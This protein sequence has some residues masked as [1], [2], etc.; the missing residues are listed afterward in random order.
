MGAV[1]HAHPLPRSAPEAQGIASSAIQRFI[2]AAER[3][4]QHLHSIMIMRHG[5]VVAEGWWAPY[6]P[7]RPHMLFSLSKSFTATGIGL[8]VAEGR[9][10]LNDAVAS[11][12]PDDA[13]AAPSAHLAA[14]RVRDLLSMATGHTVDPSSLRRGDAGDN[15]VRGFFAVPVEHAPGTHFLYNSGASYMLSAIVQR[16][17][18]QTLLDYLTP[19][20]F[21]PLGIHGATWETDPRGISVG[22]WGLAVTTEE[23]AKFGQLYLQ[24]GLWAG[25]RLLSEAWI[26]EAT[27]KQISNADAADPHAPADWQQGY[28][29][30][31]WRCQH[32]AYRGDGAFGQFCV[33]MPD[34]DAVIAITSGLP[35]M[36]AVLNLIW[37]HLLP[38]MGP[39]RRKNSRGQAN[40]EQRLSGLRLP[41]Q[42]GATGS[43][44]AAEVAGKRFAFEENTWGI[45]SMAFAFDAA[46]GRFTQRNAHGEHAIAFAWSD[47]RH[48]HAD[49]RVWHGRTRPEPCAASAAWTAD[50]A[51]NLRLWFTETPFRVE[52]ACQFAPGGERVEVTIAMN[53]G[54]QPLE[55][56]RL[57]G[58]AE[59]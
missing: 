23:I 2:D 41:P 8:A 5:H 38:A 12:F 10:S 52:V 32:N 34:Q 29:Y 13:P 14:M 9:L 30:Q 33:V 57:T 24:R 31:F 18:G 1:A 47:W 50:H 46:G 19:R 6:T 56:A 37:A 45:Q 28:G 55:P 25:R 36:Q 53:V 27:A 49:M 40:L 20:L 59:R 35:N 42:L 54:F 21:E 15:W 39:Q 44:V 58:H 4:I 17:T 11:F 16:V 26:A 48:D 22:G 43:P 3:D 7:E 51:L